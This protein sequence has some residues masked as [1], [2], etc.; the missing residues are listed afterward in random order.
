M[1]LLAAAVATVGPAHAGLRADLDREL[2]TAPEL[3]VVC[4]SANEALGRVQQ[5]TALL[6]GALAPAA[7]AGEGS[8]DALAPFLEGMRATFA[9]DARLAISWWGDTETL[10]LGF[11]TLLSAPELARR[12][13]ELDPRADGAVFEGPR[14]WGI[15]EKDGDEIG[16]SVDEGWARVTHGP[17][18]ERQPRSLPSAMLASIPEAPGCVLALHLSDEDI[19]GLDIATHLSFTEG[20]PATFVAA[21]PG[22][23]SSD[24]I[25]LGGAVPPEVITAEPPQA[26][27]VVG[28]GLDSVDFSMFLKGKELKAARRVQNMFPVT[29]GTTVALLGWDPVPRVAAVVPFAGRMPA[30][31]VARRTWR[32]ASL[33]NLEVS[34]VDP[35]HLVIKAGSVSILAT[36]RDNRLDLSTDAGALNAMQQARSAGGEPWVSGAVAELAG[37]WPLVMTTRVL[38]GGGGLPARLLS[39]PLYVALDL[40]EALIKG[41]IDVPLPL[42]DI[43]ALA[44]QV[45]SARK[46]A[47]RNAGEPAESD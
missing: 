43:V 13:V 11:D 20:Q 24:A 44:Q 21:L 36:A 31:K 5:A 3:A 40:D 8:S 34:R 46:A 35:T 42:A 18:P 45:N 10:Q 4:T 29:G 32:M 17:S 12:F 37:S 19:G 25:L 22:L 15:R 14:G 38:P 2:G 7:A 9:P 27:V 26:V 28:F 39:R 30:G 33:A 47:E 41:L 23:G 6:G 16:V 1:F